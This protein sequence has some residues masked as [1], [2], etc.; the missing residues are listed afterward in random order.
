MTSKAQSHSMI[1]KGCWQHMR[2]PIPIRGPLSIPVRLLG[3]KISRMNPNLCNICE[4][5][6]T[7]VKRQEADHRAARRCCSLTS[8]ATRLCRR[9][10]RQARS[11]TCCTASP[12]SAPRPSGSA[13]ASSTSSSATR[14]SPS[15]TS[16]SCATITCAGGAGRPGYPAA[17]GETQRARRAAGT[18]SALGLGIGIHTGMASIGEI[19]TAYKDFTIIGPVVNMA[20]RIQGAGQAPER[21]SSAMP[22]T[23]R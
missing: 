18:A 1:C 6:F 19:G 14:C 13:T 11:P 8:A 3:V 15:S 22:S 9:A 7:R 20:S 12:T 21:F 4:T 23:S 2:M 17:L 16:R 5:M 10:P